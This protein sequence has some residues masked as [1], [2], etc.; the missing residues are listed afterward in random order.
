MSIIKAL[1]ELLYVISL[2][3]LSIPVIMLIASTKLYV[4]EN[5]KNKRGRY[6]Y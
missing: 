3:V 4:Y 6:Y 1:A 2:L 5:R